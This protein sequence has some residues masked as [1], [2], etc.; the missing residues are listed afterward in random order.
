MKTTLSI[1]AVQ[2]AYFYTGIDLSDKLKVAQLAK[3]SFGDVLDG[4]PT[5][6][7]LPNDAPLEIPRVVLQSKNNIHLCNIAGNRLDF[8]I[9]IPEGGEYMSIVDFKTSMP[10]IVDSLNNILLTELLV[11]PFRLGLILTYVAL[12]KIGGLSF[13]KKYFIGENKDLSVEAQVHKLTIESI[14][15]IKVNNWIRVI[16][17]ENTLPTGE[18]PLT[19][20]SDVNS[21]ITEKVEYTDK[22]CLSF[23]NSSLDLSL[24]TV[25]QTINKDN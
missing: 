6:L 16:A 8:I 19:V 20:T 17:K 2:I 5:I 3:A 22:L 18:N 25:E 24:K 13:V 10:K 9:R 21:L 11:K 23:F 14:D 12:P 4:E 15:S 7:P 1:Q